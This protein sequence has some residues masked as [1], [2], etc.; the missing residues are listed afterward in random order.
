[1]VLCENCGH[2]MEYF[3]QGHSCGWTCPVCGNGIAT[4]YFEP[5]E[6]DETN[7]TITIHS[8]EPALDGIKIVARIA[9]CNFL[10]ARKYLLSGTLS[11]SEKAMKIREWARLLNDSHVSYA[12]EPDFPYPVNDK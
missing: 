9:E 5:I 11:L 6:L 12:I 7:Y 4:S 3:Q 10:E 2:E 8:Q 1:M